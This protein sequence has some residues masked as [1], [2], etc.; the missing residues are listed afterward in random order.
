[1]AR[2]CG[3]GRGSLSDPFVFGR[4]DLGRDEQ[5]D[6]VANGKGSIVWQRQWKTEGRMSNEQDDEGEKLGA[7][8]GHFEGSH[9][10]GH[11]TAHTD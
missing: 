9:A 3:V 2:V 7:S 8:G 11:C 4:N 6:L 10:V 1:M 5:G